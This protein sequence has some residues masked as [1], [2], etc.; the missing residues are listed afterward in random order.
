MSLRENFESS[1]N[2]LAFVELNFV[3]DHWENWTARGNKRHR[4]VGLRRG[5]ARHRLK[6]VAIRPPPAGPH[7]DIMCHNRSFK[8]AKSDRVLVLYLLNELR[9]SVFG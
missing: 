3:V 1:P 5:N 4:L 8:P 7:T 6:R 2:N 9:F